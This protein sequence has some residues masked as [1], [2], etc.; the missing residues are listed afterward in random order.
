MLALQRKLLKALSD[1]GVPLMAGTDATEI[2]PTAGFGLHHELQEFVHDGL[3]PYQALETATVNPAR[4]L[5]NSAEFGTIEVGKRADMLLLASNPLADIS[6]TQDI[7]GLVVRGRW[8][9][10]KELTGMLQ[11]VPGAYL[12]EQHEVES[13]LKDDPARASRYLDDRD[14]LGR[15]AAFAISEAASKESVAGLVRML[16]AVRQSNPKT[17]L[18]SEDGINALGYGLLEKKLYPQAVAVLTMNTDR[19]PNSANAW[20]SLAD[21]CSHSGDLLDAVKNYKK[22]L[23]TDA[24]YVN[25]EFARK[26]IAEHEQR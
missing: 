23:E 2:G 11:E 21:A 1:A 17:G 5:R 13:M 14:P 6:H 20:D 4:Y 9:D 12:R 19:F 3:T 8:L 22:A 25:A 26:F 7:V 24:E 16:N 18:V 10:E 15:L